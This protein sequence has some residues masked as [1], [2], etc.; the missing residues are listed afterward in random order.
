[1]AAAAGDR[2]AGDRL[3]ADR[4]RAAGAAGVETSILLLGQPIFTVLWGVLLF[5]ERLSVLQWLGSR[6]C[7]P[8]LPRFGSESE[9]RS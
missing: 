7:S 9:V 1:V 8:G 3:A 2:I 4:P 6:S 5:D